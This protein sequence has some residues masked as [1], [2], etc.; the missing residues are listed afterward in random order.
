MTTLADIQR[1][2]GTTPDGKWGPNTAAAIAKALDA[3]KPAPVRSDAFTALAIEHLRA[4]EGVMPSAYQD[5][6]G[7]WTIGV[8][9]LI[10]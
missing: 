6:L 3:L 7:Y 10:D 8:G 2:V 9:R 5:P 4:E 1:R